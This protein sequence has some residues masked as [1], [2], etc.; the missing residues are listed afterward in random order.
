M[1]SKSREPGPKGQIHPFPSA[2][3]SPVG[4]PCPT[5]PGKVSLIFRSLALTTKSVRL[6]PRGRGLGL[7]HF[8]VIRVESL[9][10]Q[11]RR[12]RGTSTLK[13]QLSNLSFGRR[14]EPSI[15]TSIS[16]RQRDSDGFSHYPYKSTLCTEPIPIS[17]SG[18]QLS[19]GKRACCR[20]N[21]TF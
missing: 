11:L 1:R 9:G 14:P 21:C 17:Q 15:S 4:S 19:S 2:N 18:G 12:N 10:I 20:V 8:P 6:L 13:S 3:P 7:S 5:S 16:F